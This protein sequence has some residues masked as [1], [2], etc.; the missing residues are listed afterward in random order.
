MVVAYYISGHRQ[1]EKLTP[2]EVEA[3]TGALLCKVNMEKLSDGSMDLETIK[4]QTGYNSNHVFHFSLSAMPKEQYENTVTDFHRE[5]M[6]LEHEIWFAL[7]GI[8][9]YDLR[10][11]NDEW[12]QILL[13][14][15]DLLIIPSECYHRLSL[16]EN[17]PDCKVI[18]LFKHRSKWRAF[19]RPAHE[20]CNNFR[21]R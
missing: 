8:A 4:R 19:Y 16:V 3:H 13:F 20:H 21:C 15:G 1:N 11:K 17:E 12:I 10:D 2:E 7:E 18:R 5:H 9:Y 6:H 14:P